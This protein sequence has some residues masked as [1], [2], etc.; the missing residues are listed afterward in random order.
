MR[1]I[2]EVA[3]WVG[4][5]WGVVAVEE[6]VGWASMCGRSHGWCPCRRARVGGDAERVPRSGEFGCDLGFAATVVP[7]IIT[8]MY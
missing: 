4:G 3:D 6:S 8:V 2:G 5:Q 1:V 7:H